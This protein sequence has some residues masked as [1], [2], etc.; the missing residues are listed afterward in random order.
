MHEMDA[1]RYKRGPTA[2]LRLHEV[3]DRVQMRESPERLF[4]PGAAREDD[5][6]ADTAEIRIDP[7]GSAVESA[8]R[9]EQ[10]VQHGNAHGACGG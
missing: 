6:T 9:R 3:A 2:L 1:V 5:W 8:V 4:R 10:A 7:K